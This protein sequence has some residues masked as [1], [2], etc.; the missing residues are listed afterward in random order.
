MIPEETVTNLLNE[1]SKTC[2]DAIDGIFKFVFSPLLKYKIKKDNDLEAYK[3]QI[4]QNISNIPSE[5]LVEPPLNIIGPALEASKFYID[6]KELRNMFAK[7]ISSSMNIETKDFAHPSFIEIIKQMSPLDAE[8]LTKFVNSNAIPMV[9]IRFENDLGNGVDF[10]TH[11]LNNDSEAIDTI[12]LSITNLIRLG[13]ID[14]SY[15]YRFVDKSYYS[16]FYKHPLYLHYQSLLDDSDFKNHMNDLVLLGAL[17]GHPPNKVKIKEGRADL[18]P[19]GHKFI[20][21][22]L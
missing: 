10:K 2:G 22:C 8:I 15:M 19:L 17:P 20:S 21:I 3:Q 14:V 6:S 4:H 5:N 18:T 13:I 1:P 12:S 7:L 11:I 16:D 9:K